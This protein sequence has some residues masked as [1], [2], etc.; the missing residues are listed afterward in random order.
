MK[1]IKSNK[2]L[3][4]LASLMLIVSADG[5]AYEFENAYPLTIAAEIGDQ[6][7]DKIRIELNGR[8]ILITL[9]INNEGNS[10]K[11]IGFAAYSPFF[12]QL[13]EGE[14]HN[15]KTFSD[16]AV[17]FN[18][19]PIKLLSSH[20]GFFL[21]R[22]ITDNL[23]KAGLNPLPST[24]YSA[25]K[26]KK[27]PKLLG[28][29]VNSWQ[30]YVSYSWGLHVPP[31]STNQM[32]ISYRA[33]PQFGLEQISDVRFAQQVLQH[34]GKPDEVR[35]HLA[36]LNGASDYALVERYEIPIKFIQMTEVNVKVSQPTINWLRA[37]PVFSMVCGIGENAQNRASLI[38]AIDSINE[39]ISVLVISQ[40]SPPEKRPK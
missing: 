38:G 23:I 18:D 25:K 24:D 5:A 31:H 36:A 14:E 1:T 37:K 13:G 40:L 6:N 12:D 20:R 21:G 32:N 34:C 28:L 7:L 4:C 30:G 17:S 10:S 9:A 19:K 8:D 29:K 35:K 2:C 26:L 27:L 33:L 16:I 22:D 39:S 3:L 11:R 15:D